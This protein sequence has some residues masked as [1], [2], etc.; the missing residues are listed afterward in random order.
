[1]AGYV[2]FNY[3]IKDRT[4]IDQ[5]TQLSLPVNSQYGAEVIVG[6]PVKAL[7]GHALSHIVILKFDSFEAAQIFY[8]SPEHT[9]LSKLRNEITEG[10]SAIVPGD[11]ETQK[12]VDTGYF[13]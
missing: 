7:E 13:N 10:W 5:L 12:L 8:H 6:S 3:K 11:S 9:E 2:I 1:M 4:K